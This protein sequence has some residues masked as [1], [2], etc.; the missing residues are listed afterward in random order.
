MEYISSIILQNAVAASL[1]SCL[2]QL[3]AAAAADMAMETQALLQK[4]ATQSP[5][6]SDINNVVSDHTRLCINMCVDELVNSTVTK[7]QQQ[8]YKSWPEDFAEH[9]SS[10]CKI[11]LCLSYFKHACLSGS[12]PHPVRIIQVACRWMK[13]IS[14]TSTV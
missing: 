5:Q 2:P 12:P 13:A 7:V 14:V 3:L 1:D 10:I 4:A 6:Q 9:H 11:E 8:L